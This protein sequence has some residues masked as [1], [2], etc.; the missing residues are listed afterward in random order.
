MYSIRMQPE[1]PPYRCRLCGAA[2]YRR[3]THRGPDGVMTYSGLYRCSGC[4][5]TFADP[6]A[7]R[8]SPAIANPT[9]ATEKQAG[10]RPTQPQAAVPSDA[11]PGASLPHVARLSTWGSMP[12]GCATPQPSATAMPT[13]QRSKRPHGVPVGA[14]TR[15]FA[16]KCEADTGA[17][18]ELPKPSP[19]SALEVVRQ[20]AG[21]MR[22]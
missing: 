18:K 17:T 11:T 13:T 15:D 20:L 7:W 4:S 22:R 5:V 16:A 3:L 12:Q 21:W 8:E 10:A 19:A 9:R 1:T 14:S 2:S 6:A